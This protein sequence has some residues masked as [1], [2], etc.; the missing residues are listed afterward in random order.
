MEAVGTKMYVAPDLVSP[1]YLAQLREL[2]ARRDAT[3]GENAG[4]FK[5]RVVNICRDFKCRSVLDYGCG[6]GQLIDALPEYL[7]A[8]GYDPA[9]QHFADPPTPADLVVCTDMLEHVEPEYV[10]GVLDDIARLAKKA[11]MIKLATVEARK[12]LADGRNAHLIVRPASWW[13]P[14]FWGRWFVR[15]MVDS[16]TRLTVFCTIKG[17]E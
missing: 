17:K 16:G 6:K 5:D 13:L 14:H 1:E 3:F 12:T 10:V 2:H 7:L 8:Q 9:I 11:V 15:E 4:R